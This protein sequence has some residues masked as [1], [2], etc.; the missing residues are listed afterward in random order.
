MSIPDFDE[1][2]D[3][4]EGRP[5][6]Q[7]PA[8][9]PLLSPW[10]ES[11]PRTDA[12]TSDIGNDIGDAGWYSYDSPL[13]ERAGED[14]P[15]RWDSPAPGPFSASQRQP[16]WYPGHYPQPYRERATDVERASIV[17]HGQAAQTIAAQRR[18]QQLAAALWTFWG[19]LFLVVGTA[20]SAFSYSSADPGDAYIIWTGALTTGAIWTLYGIAGLTR[21][22]ELPYPAVRVQREV[23][24][25]LLLAALIFLAVRASFQNFKVEGHSMDPS[26]ADGEFL[27]V[28]KLTYAQIDLSMFDFL[29]FFDAGDNPMHYLWGA[30]DR[31]DV[32]VFRAPTSPDRDFIKRIIGLPGDTVQI[33][34]ESGA[35]KVNGAQLTEDYILGTTNCQQSCEWTVP[36]ANTV[37]S[38][39]TC[40]SA[41]CYFVLGD[42]R[43]N[44]SDSRQGWLVP[45]ENIVGKALVTYWHAGEPE[46][47]LAPN[48]SVGIADQASAEQ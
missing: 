14:R 18:D 47:E 27:I 24:E 20:V 44:S 10:E 35:V 31:G 48:H 37:Q 41:A 4:K 30:P 7:S 1:E 43:Q 25:T 12:F 38:R 32:I 11:R 13:S 17:Q 33:D 29:P 3:G 15:F 40:G 2:P 9:D 21:V 26:L 39:Q 42:N 45:K 19:I 16:A 5:R 6:R 8:F 46:L 28:N 23:V 36:R 22:I 34:A